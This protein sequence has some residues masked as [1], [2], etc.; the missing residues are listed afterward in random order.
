MKI[1]TAI[2]FLLLGFLL[3][4]C[5]PTPTPTATV[6]SSQA[7]RDDCAEQNSDCYE[8]E[9]EKCK[10]LFWVCEQ[11]EA[12]DK[13]RCKSEARATCTSMSE[14]CTGNY[15]LCLS[16]CGGSGSS[17]RSTGPEHECP[18]GTTRDQLGRCVSRLESGNLPE[19]I[20]PNDHCPAGTVPGQDDN[21]IPTLYQLIALKGSGDVWFLVCAPGT[22]P[23][24][25]GG[26]VPDIPEPDNGDIGS[27]EPRQCP[28]GTSPSPDDGACVPIFQVMDQGNL[29]NAHIVENLINTGALGPNITPED[30]LFLDYLGVVATFDIQGAIERTAQFFSAVTD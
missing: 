21:C 24:P 5:K 6:D 4:A 23:N 17:R 28:P 26:C 19:D 2:C 8:I 3:V 7:C 16:G 1:S 18:L 29:F 14:N 15:D 10:G 20:D 25:I 27:Q 11:Q 30:E 9:K 12:A 22:K 13:P